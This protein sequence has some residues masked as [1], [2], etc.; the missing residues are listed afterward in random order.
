MAKHI[1][2]AAPQSFRH[3]SQPDQDRQRDIL[4]AVCPPNFINFKASPNHVAQTS[5]P[6]EPLINQA[7]FIKVS[8]IEF[9]NDLGRHVSDAY[10]PVKTQSNKDL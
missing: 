9:L 1:Y 4:M 10:Q 5:K 2:S 6:F 7:P 3:G 8:E